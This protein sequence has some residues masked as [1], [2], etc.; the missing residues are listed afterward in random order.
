MAGKKERGESPVEVTLVSTHLLKFNYIHSPGFLFSLDVK[1]DLQNE[2]LQSPFEL[3]ALSR[4][5][6]PHKVRFQG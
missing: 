1:L 3:G 2:G 4:S 5:N 6:L